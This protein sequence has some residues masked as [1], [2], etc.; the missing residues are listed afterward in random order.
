MRPLL[1]FAAALC[2]CAPAAV[3]RTGGLP[4]ILPVAASPARELACALADQVGP[5]LA[6]SP[7]DA[8]AVAWAV[9]KMKEL[10]LANVRTEPVK[11]VRWER[12]EA[13]AELT[14]P[15]HKPL[16]V[17]ALGGSTATPPGGV[18]A[19]VVRVG[20]L[21]ELRALP[22]ERVKGRVVFYDAVMERLVTGEGYG[23]TVGV[24]SRGALEAEKKGAVAS[25]IRTVG[26]S[27][28]RFPHTGN[29]R[30]AG[31]PAAALAI[32]DAEL[33]RRAILSSQGPVRVR[34]SS[35]ARLAGEAESANVIGEVP[36]NQKPEEVVLLG[37]H[38]DAWDL[39]DGATDDAAGVGVVLEVASLLVM[40][41]LPRTVRVVLFANEENG[42]KGAAAYVEKYRA[43]LPKHVAA[44]EVD[45]GAGRAL[46]VR[47]A[48]GAQAEAAMQPLEAPLKEMALTLAPDAEAGGADT[49]ELDGVPLLQI[50][51][52]A[53]RYFDIHHSADDTC[54]KIVEEELAHVAKV[55][56]MLTRHVGQAGVDLGRRPP[57]KP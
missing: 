55:A 40:R 41:P 50:L 10:G 46:G 23:K 3:Q 35:T 42:L 17:A 18:E 24:R 26:T 57:P 48:A 16:T 51:Q 56:G 5:R 38:L 34:F 27:E 8:Q 39:G 29:M 12:G 2:G 43:D 14:A 7:G 53:S 13:S 30:P 36:G 6:G 37:A 20:S 52:D 15:F 45:M 9:A 19:E 54:D 44:L 1:L 25:L 33:L 28:A 49:G 11:V 31:I 21:D 22:E 47:Y 4:D 32:P